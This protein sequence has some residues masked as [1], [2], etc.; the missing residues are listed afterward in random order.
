MVNIKGIISLN[1]FDTWY[2]KKV[3]ENVVEPYGN[4][5]SNVSVRK[6][7]DLCKKSQIQL[8]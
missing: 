8:D 1:N 4:T 6:L 3:L 7:I 2:G 5:R